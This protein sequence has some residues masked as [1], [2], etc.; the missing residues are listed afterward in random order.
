MAISNISNSNPLSSA[1]SVTATNNDSAANRTQVQE[2]R[3]PATI[4]TLSAQ[5]KKL[6]SEQTA[7]THTESQAQTRSNQALSVTQA[8]KAAVTKVETG[9]RDAAEAPV[10]RQQDESV[11]RKR[12]NTYA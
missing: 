1:R 12:I 3:Q 8:D 4:V 7:I 10:A 6:N 9:A 11:E 5:A 2:D